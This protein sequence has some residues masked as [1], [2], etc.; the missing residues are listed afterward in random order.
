MKMICHVWNTDTPAEFP[1]F[2][3]DPIPSINYAEPQFI[4]SAKDEIDLLKLGM[5]T[6]T[7]SPLDYLLS[8]DPDLSTKP[9]PRLAAMER[10]DRNLAETAKVLD[11][12][13]RYQTK[14]VNPQ[15]GRPV[16]DNQ[17]LPSGELV[18]KNEQGGE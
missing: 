2:S 12:R 15:G 7:T 18:P 14:A 9:D 16:E 5:E 4:Q 1:K 13:Q 6:G 3:T 8:K 17:H 10:I 11:A